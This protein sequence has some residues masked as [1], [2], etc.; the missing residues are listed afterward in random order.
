MPLD[1]PE[2]FRAPR[3]ASLC[4]CRYNRSRHPTEIARP[5][6]HRFDRVERETEDW[7][8]SVISRVERRSVDDWALALRNV[9]VES[10]S[11]DYTHERTPTKSILP[12]DGCIRHLFGGLGVTIPISTLHA[13]ANSGP[14]PPS[15]ASWSTPTMDM[16]FIEEQASIWGNQAYLAP[17]PHV[18]Q[19]SGHTGCGR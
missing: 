18:E 11:I 8:G 5:T 9:L 19:S 4:S 7:I 2:S 16:R 1:L 3:C 14:A 10:L 12:M 6:G 15:L 17:L 13:G